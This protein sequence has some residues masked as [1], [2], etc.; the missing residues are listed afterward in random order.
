MA[1]KKFQCSTCGRKF[2][3]AAHLA[4]HR[5]ATHG[6]GRAKMARK[7]AGRRTA[8][9][10]VGGGTARVGTVISAAGARRELRAYY[11]QLCSRRDQL[12]AEIAN[13][14]SVLETLGGM[15]RRRGRPRG[16]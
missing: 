4:R 7:T 9:R 16:R 15:R 5:N 12:D 11:S 8:R 3:M 6:R 10:Q 1:D 2:S 14:E 13:I